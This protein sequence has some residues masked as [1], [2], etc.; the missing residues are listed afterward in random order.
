M[1]HTRK[2]YLLD[3][4]NSVLTQS[5]DQSFYEII[6]VKAFKDELIENSLRE[7]CVKFIDTSEQP[8]GAKVLV[9]VENCRGEFIAFLEDDDLFG[10]NKIETLIEIFMNEKVGYYHNGFENIDSKGRSLKRSRNIPS[11]SRIEVEPQK[12]NLK[13]MRN[14]IKSR[15]FFNLSCITVRR[16]LIYPYLW[17]L[18]ELQVAVDTFIFYVSL[19]SNYINVIDME[20]HTK[21]RI[22]P[23]NFSLARENHI[24]QFKSKKIPFFLDD[25]KGYVVISE[26][27]KRKELKDC[28]SC[29]LMLPAYAL[30]ILDSNSAPNLKTDFSYFIKCLINYQ[31]IEL[32][33]LF[34]DFLLSKFF[35]RMS[36]SLFLVVEKIRISF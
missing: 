29:R 4:V 17:A 11:P 2:D 35:R 22:H 20:K 19:D 25:M 21:Y 32:L 13:I 9:G 3:A 7:N 5:V 1:A 30:Y 8:L 12:N 10:Y 23:G 15:A 18:R 14:L 6:V 24:S 16:K 28:L 33:L 26:I 36:I 31:S 34:G 27:V